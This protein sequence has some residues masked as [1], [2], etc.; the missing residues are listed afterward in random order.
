[1]EFDYGTCA[2]RNTHQFEYNENG[3][4]A[5]GYDRTGFNEKRMSIF[6]MR[7]E[8]PLTPGYDKYGYDGFGYDCDGFDT[9]GYSKDGYDTDGY[10]D[11]GINREGF[12]M[13]GEKVDNDPVR[14]EYYSS[15]FTNY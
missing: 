1:M 3:Q 6:G 2:L 12:N 10:N 7:Y 13:N 5:L 11:L 9:Y 8:N 15:N 14:N 4:D